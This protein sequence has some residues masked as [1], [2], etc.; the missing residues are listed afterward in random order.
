MNVAFKELVHKI[1]EKIKHKPYFRWPG[2]M[3]GDSIRWNE[4]RSDGI[5]I[6]NANIIRIRGIPPSNVGHSRTTWRS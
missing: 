5:K 1:L 6:C 2:K 4:I 3:G